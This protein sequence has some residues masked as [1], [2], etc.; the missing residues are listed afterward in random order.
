MQVMATHIEQWPID[1][2]V[3]Y[4]RNPR[5]NGAAVDR[6]CASIRESGSSIPVLA[7]GDGTVVNG[8]PRIK[9]ARTP[10]LTEPG[11]SPASSCCRTRG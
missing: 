7:R 1:R 3:F 5:K 11:G 4:A 10:G 8:L 2:L 9:A 6:M